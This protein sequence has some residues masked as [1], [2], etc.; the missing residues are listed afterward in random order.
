MSD[1]EVISVPLLAPSA[2]T[3]EVIDTDMGRLVIRGVF[4][5]TKDEVI[6]GGEVTK[7]KLVIP[8]YAHHL[9]AGELLEDVEI[10][11]LKVGPQDTKEVQ[12]GSMCGMSYKPGSKSDVQEGDHFEFFTRVTK[13][14]A[15]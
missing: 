8:S 14:R 7:G 11:T 15:L 12:E 13:Q 10:L 6:C 9:R 2:G 5:T 1:E 4:R 3:P